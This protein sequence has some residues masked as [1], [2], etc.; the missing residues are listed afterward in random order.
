MD[1]EQDCPPYLETTRG[2]EE[3]LPLLLAI[4]KEK[5]VI[6]TFFVTGE[7]ARKFPERIKEISRSGHEVGCHGDLHQRFDKL[8]WDQ[9]KD[10]V[11]R[12][13]ETLEALLNR[14]PTS[15]RAPNLQMPTEYMELLENTGYRVDSSIAAY[16]PPFHRR[17][18][19]TGPMLRV[20][21]TI[22]SSVLRLPLP[23]LKSCFKLLPSQPVFFLHP[24]ELVDLSEE[25]IRLDCRLGTGDRLAENLSYLMDY[26][27]GRETRFITMQ[28]LYEKQ[29]Q[30]RRD[31]SAGR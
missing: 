8:G 30:V 27:K 28:D 9:A 6:A 25:Q 10:S 24:W 20:P 2:M 18:F 15:F 1:V 23:L 4:L 16:K 31:M 7:M 3:G 11:V 14:R 5:G 22:T 29:T 21:A 12:G 26:Y 17:P 19:Y 13:T